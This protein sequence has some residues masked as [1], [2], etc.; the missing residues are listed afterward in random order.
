MSQAFYFL[1]PVSSLPS[2]I[3]FNY[4]LFPCSK[5]SP[6]AFGACEDLEKMIVETI[7]DRKTPIYNNQDY[8]EM[9]I[10]L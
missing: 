9:V 2:P 8:G 7:Y 10:K 1:Y 4:Y 6:I 5:G 3:F